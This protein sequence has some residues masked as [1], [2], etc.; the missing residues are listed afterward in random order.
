MWET[1]HDLKLITGPTKTPSLLRLLKVYFISEV[2]L[3]LLGGEAGKQVTTCQRLG[4]SGSV[5][6]RLALHHLT[7]K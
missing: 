6:F 5:W 2:N 7:H 4:I 3:P 1:N